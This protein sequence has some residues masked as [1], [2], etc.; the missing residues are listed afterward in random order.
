MLEPA[1]SLEELRFQLKNLGM[2][3]LGFVSLC[4]LVSLSVAHSHA[5]LHEL[6]SMCLCQAT[7]EVNSKRRQGEDGARSDAQPDAMASAVGECLEQPI[8]MD[9]LDHDDLQLPSGH[10]WVP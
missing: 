4:C 3:C 8:Q 2:K 9:E 6:A 5:V 10:H 1:P 7:G